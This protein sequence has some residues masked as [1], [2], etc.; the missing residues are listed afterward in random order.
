MGAN[1][2]AFGRYQVNAITAYMELNIAHDW[3]ASYVSLGRGQE[4]YKLKWGSVLTPTYRSILGCNS[5]FWS[6]YAGYHVLRSAVKRYTQSSKSPRWVR[7]IPIRYRV[8]RHTV[9]RYVRHMT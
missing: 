2:E 1:C 4:P 3:D 5:L 9:S 8:L 6:L 7:S